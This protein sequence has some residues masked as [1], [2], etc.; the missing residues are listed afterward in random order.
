M[1]FNTRCWKILLL[2]GAAAIVSSCVEG[3]REGG[4]D[5]QVDWKD[6]ANKPPGFEDDID[7][8]SSY[9]AGAGIYVDSIN[10]TISTDL[11]FDDRAPSRIS[12][13]A[14]RPRPASMRLPT[15]PRQHMCQ[16]RLVGLPRRA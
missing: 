2:V 3:S 5:N 10:S 12:L 13:F 11:L 4:T 15:K 7:D 16:Q 9:T 8:G 6:V 14:S 1:S